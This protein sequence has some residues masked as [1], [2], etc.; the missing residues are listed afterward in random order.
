MQQCVDQRAVGIAGCRMNHHTGRLVD[1]DEVI[2]LVQDV[3]RNLL[4]LR[5]CRFG[6]GN[7]NRIGFAG[8][9]LLLAGRRGLVPEADLPVADQACDAVS[10]YMRRHPASQ[11]GVEALALLA[12]GDGEGF[13]FRVVCA[14]RHRILPVPA[15]A[16]LVGQ[17]NRTGRK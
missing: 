10:R 1:D 16:G 8:G 5:G 7:E 14:T 11:P 17:A 3:E 6:R 9:D 2:V 13:Y 12:F 4:G 15:V